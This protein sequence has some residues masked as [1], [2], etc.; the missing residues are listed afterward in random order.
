MHFSKIFSISSLL[1]AASATSVSYDVGYDDP[2]RSLTAVSCS[3]GVNGVMWKYNWNV[4]GDV[5]G[6]PYIGGA[7]A[8]GGWNSPNCGTCWKA[9]FQGRSIHVLAIDHAANGLNIAQAAMN[10]LT[11][12]RA[13]Q[14][15]RIEADVVQVPLGE[16]GL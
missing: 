16:C 11:N 15:G 1:A 3:D 5:K 14:L 13:V 10:D 2:S 7:Q 6:F 4:Q 9:T 8:V 12:G